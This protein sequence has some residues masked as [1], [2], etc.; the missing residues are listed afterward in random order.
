MFWRI[1][2]NSL[3]SSPTS[4]SVFRANKQEPLTSLPSMY[5]YSVVDAD[6]EQVTSPPR[7]WWKPTNKLTS[8]LCLIVICS[9]FP[10]GFLAGRAS[11]T[12]TKSELERKAS[13][14]SLSCILTPCTVVLFFVHVCSLLLSRKNL[15]PIFFSGR[16]VDCI[17]IQPYLS[18]APPGLA[19]TRPNMVLTLPS[20]T[21][22]L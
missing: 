18:E 15:V 5:T 13:P 6:E 16:C 22:L 20:Q 3:Q 8:V 14:R 4:T 21:R 2:V 9:L 7:S 1:A 12:A 10:T 11:T 17:S 19:Q